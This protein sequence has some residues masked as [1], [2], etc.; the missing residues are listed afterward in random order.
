MHRRLDPRRLVRVAVHAVPLLVLAACAPRSS[1]ILTTEIQDLRNRIY[2]IQKR[3]AETEV[4]IQEIRE[5]IAAGGGQSARPVPN[6]AAAGSDTQPFE[7]P[8][9]PGS[10]VEMDTS[11]P[12]RALPDESARWEGPQPGAGAAG[13]AG[14]PVGEPPSAEGEHDRLYLDGY[15]KFNTG[16]HASAQRLFQEFLA[17]APG[18]ELADDAQ[19]WVGES[20]FAQKDYPRAILEFRRLIDQY[21]FGNRVPHAFLRIG[22]SYLALGERDRAAESL[23]TVVEAFPKSDVAT[24]AR[25]TLDQ[26]RKP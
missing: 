24:V 5:M 10:T 4:A 13:S 16:D 1:G 25:A 7:A 26:I 17:R 11:G 20:F 22:L 19:Y 18:S 23:E 3:Q 14:R 8:A 6:P 9:V 15:A 2:E 12:T 21:P